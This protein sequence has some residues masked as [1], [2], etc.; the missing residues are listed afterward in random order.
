MDLQVELLGYSP[1]KVFTFK[2]VLFVPHVDEL[3]VLDD[4]CSYR[5]LTVFYDYTRNLV[6]VRVHR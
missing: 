3:V 5:V 6:I 1:S 4:D 2:D